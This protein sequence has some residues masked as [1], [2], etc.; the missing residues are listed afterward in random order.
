MSE[1][2][3]QFASDIILCRI[4][5]E[6]YSYERNNA[7]LMLCNLVLLFF[8]CRAAIFIMYNFPIVKKGT[9]EAFETI[10]AAKA[11]VRQLA[12]AIA[13]ETGMV[14]STVGWR[15]NKTCTCIVFNLSIS[16][17]QCALLCL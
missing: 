4:I 10:F 16:L 6:Q 3:R 14:R 15:W 12:L 1:Y 13:L 7:N 2:L 17:M 9:L 11:V 8:F 5:G